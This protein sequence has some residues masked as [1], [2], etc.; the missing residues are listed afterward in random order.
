M[1]PLKYYCRYPS[2]CFVIFVLHNN[3]VLSFLGLTSLLAL[4]DLSNHAFERGADI[5][6]ESGAGLGPSTL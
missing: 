3:A 6:V 2:S 4:F 5:L 1:P